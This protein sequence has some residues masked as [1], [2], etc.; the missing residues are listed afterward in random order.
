[1]QITVDIPDAVA[2]DVAAMLARWN[3]DTPPTEDVAAYIAACVADDLSR[4]V[5]RHTTAAVALAAREDT[6][7]PEVVWR[8]T[9]TASRTATKARS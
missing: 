8:N 7:R 2:E 5:V 6:D 3:E 4:R 9:V 1:M